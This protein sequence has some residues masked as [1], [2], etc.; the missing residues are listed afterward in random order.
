ML[1]DSRER[2]AESCVTSMTF[3][4]SLMNAG[5]VDEIR[6]VAQPII[7]GGG[8]PPFKDLKRR[9]ALTL[10]T[11]RPLEAGA[12]ATRIV[13]AAAAGHSCALTLHVASAQ[14][15]PR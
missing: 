11:A 12:Q 1:E 6:L 7:L 8:K 10:L 4:S 9:H 3:V 15:W 5:L 13:E 2:K 14:G